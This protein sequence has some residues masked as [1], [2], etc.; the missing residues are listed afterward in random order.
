M[1]G[2]ETF[3]L[4][5][6]AGAALLPLAL[7]LV[8]SSAAAAQDSGGDADIELGATHASSV[9]LG[10]SSVRSSSSSNGG[11]G[12]RS[13]RGG[14]RLALQL[15]L[16][17]INLLALAEPDQLDSGPQPSR[18][19]LVPLATPGVRLLDDGAL[20]LGLGFGFANASVDT[21]ANSQSQFGFSVS[22]T[23]SYDVVADGDGALSL[24]GL[25]DLASLGETEQCNA[26]GCMNQNDDALGLGLGLG[27][28]LRGR[29]TPSLAIGGELGWGFLS[30]N[31]DGPNSDDFVHGVFANLLFEASVGL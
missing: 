1:T 29:L 25:I 21:G 31:R 16:D 2:R 5:S 10:A 6:S 3:A 30:I 7:V 28:G 17:A 8:L 20:F 12:T 23:V 11:G 19:L 9:E 4:V 13:S 14:T 18:Q 26:G 27:V 24:L 15:R 22:P